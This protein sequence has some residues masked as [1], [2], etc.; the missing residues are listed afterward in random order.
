ML[1]IT[2]I[3]AVIL[4][5]S[6]NVEVRMVTDRINTVIKE[7]TI[8]NYWLKSVNIYKGKGDSFS[9]GNHRGLKL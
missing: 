8:P 4:K 2:R 9:C 1:G 6:C 3:T 5:E 7:G